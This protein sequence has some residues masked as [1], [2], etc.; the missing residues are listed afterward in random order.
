MISFIRSLINSR[1]GAVV[2]LLFVALI[3]LAF[4]LGD[5][6]GSGSFGGVSGGN[7]AKV[8]SQKI[9]VSELNDSLRNRLRAEQK[10]NPTLDMAKFVESGG[11]DQTLEQ[12]VNRYALALFGEQTGIAASKKQ[13]DKEIIALPGVLG[14]DGKFSKAAFQSFLSDVGVTEKMIRTD[15]TQNLYARQ[16]LTAAGGSGKSPSSLVLPYA[17]LLLEQ[18]TGQVAAISSTAFLPAQPPTDAVLTAFYRKN[19]SRYTVPEKRAVNYVLFDASIL[20][21]KVNPSDKEIADYYKSNATKFAAN[22]TRDFQQLVFLTKPA[23]DAAVAKIEGGASFDAVAR[24]T[25]LAVST[26]TGISKDA[27]AKNAS[28][29]VAATVFAATQ[30]GLSAPARGGLGWYL[31]RVSKVNAIG[32]RSLEAVR[33]EISA[34]IALQKREELLSDLTTEIEGE[35]DGG[36]TIADM[37]K[38][39][40]LKVESSPKLFADG[41]NPENPAYKPIAEMAKILPA[42]FDME[43]EGDAQLIEIVPGE[44]FAMVSIADF[45][46]AAPAPLAKLRDV[47]VQ[48]WALSEASNKAKVVAEQ[49]QKSVNAGKSLAE[50]LRA[51]GARLDAP[52]TVS[53]KR[54]DFVGENRQMP[55]PLAMMFAM[56]KGTAKTLQAGG[57]RG[58]FVVQLSEV[59]RGDASKETNLLAGRQ[60]EMD[61]MLAAEYAAQLINAA[62]VEVGTNIDKE[63]IKTMRAQLTKRNQN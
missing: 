56:K 37:A 10:D 59:V 13:V 21:D 32:A 1:W 2:A 49:V 20:G 50:S 14:L 45:E 60:A 19:A 12:L 6:T 30:G 11:L 28:K 5:V 33:G 40:N 44:K 8:G 61:G 51:T 15:F 52:Q 29:E 31:V 27:L 4:A 16:I 17:S 25:G 3:A 38:A 62:K 47:V 53:G 22:E 34:T 26:N 48:Q 42:A 23:A 41:R 18:R 58:W 9:P 63:A 43:K 36:A 35:F 54:A 55:P 57:D 39:N 24:E 7:V 46:E